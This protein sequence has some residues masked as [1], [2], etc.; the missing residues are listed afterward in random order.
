M[1]R[2]GKFYRKNEKE[3]MEA[4]GLEQTLN[5]GS[6]WIEK[7]DGQSEHVI[8]QLKSTDAQSIKIELKDIHTLEYNAEVAHKL[9]VFVVQYLVTGETFLLLKPELLSDLAKY[10]ETGKVVDN[11]LFAIEDVPD[12]RPG[13]NPGRRMIKSSSS[14]REDVRKELDSKYKKKRRSAT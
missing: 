12:T 11:R 8:A 1:K 4:L 2:S 7:E 13:S 10:L 3:V 6:G 5:S 9:P 14:A